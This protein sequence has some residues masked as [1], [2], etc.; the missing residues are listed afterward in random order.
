MTSLWSQSLAVIAMNVRSLPRRIW[1]SLAMVF[2]SAVVVAI[3]LAFLAM[4]KGFEATLSSA[5]SAD[6][7]FFL[8]SG[9]AA[10]LNSSVSREQVNL[11][12]AAPG[13][14]KNDQG[15][16]VSAELYVIV[17]GIKKSSNTEANIPL[18]GL[19]NQGVGMRRG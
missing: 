14:A 17:D 15:P 2:A 1:M 8:C 13:V 6:V 9:S 16:Q 7:A 5:G 10:E 4:A 19:H 11:I 18:R 12:E 3:L